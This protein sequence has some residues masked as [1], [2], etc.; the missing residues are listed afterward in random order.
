MSGIIGFTFDLDGTLINSTEIRKKIEQEVVREFNI[1]IDAL[2]EINIDNIVFKVM[3]RENRRNIGVS[4]MW[5]IFKKLGLPFRKRI[6][7]L[8]MASR[9]F[10]EE[11]KK[12]ELFKGIEEM[13]EFLNKNFCKYTIATTSSLKEV[14]DRLKFKYPRFYEKLNGK[15]ITRDDVKHIK[16]APDQIQLASKIMG[17]PF[18]RIVMVGD[19]FTDILMGQSVGAITIGVLTGIF[20]REK[21]FE[22]HPNL[23]LNS[24]AEIPFVFD[25]IK[26]LITNK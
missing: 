17:V 13:F 2:L 15:I 23:I 4:V 9:I 11:V 6:K 3:E 22:Y 7:A 26:E 1:K 14:E 12:I 16:P 5:E 10:K 19:L 24:A 25:K 20:N 21:F 18:N 8:K